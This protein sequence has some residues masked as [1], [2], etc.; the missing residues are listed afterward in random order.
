MVTVKVVRNYKL[1]LRIASFTYILGRLT[2]CG[3][4]NAKQFRRFSLGL[5]LKFKVIT[6]P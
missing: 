3:L 5:D 2:D 1:F 6:S 4:A